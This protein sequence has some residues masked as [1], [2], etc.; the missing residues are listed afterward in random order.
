MKTY[1]ILEGALGLIRDEKNWCRGALKME[2]FSLRA[3]GASVDR[4]RY[5][6]LGALAATD[7]GTV[8]I[9]V[10]PAPLDALDDVISGGSITRFND[11]HSHAE[12][13][14]VFQQAIQAEKVKEAREL[15]VPEPEKVRV[16]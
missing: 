12:V 3:D 8:S 4:V 14:A 6:A 2:M 9:G 13:V 10:N 1:E 11:S 16:V 5:C 7:I 15:G